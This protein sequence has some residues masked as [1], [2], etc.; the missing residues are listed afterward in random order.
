MA[1]AEGELSPLAI[2]SVNMPVLSSRT[3]VPAV[4]RATYAAP[5]DANAMPEGREPEE[6]YAHPGSHA[7]RPPAKPATRP[8][9]LSL[10][11]ARNRSAARITKPRKSVQLVEVTTVALPPPDSGTDM[12]LVVE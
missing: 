2:V 8:M 5:P 6:K 7:G 10:P 11:Q 1:T 12:M 4:M 9:E 3:M